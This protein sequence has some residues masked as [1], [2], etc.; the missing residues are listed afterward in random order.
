L[1]LSVEHFE[2]GLTLLLCPTRLAPVVEV[3][4]WANVGSADERP[5]EAGLAHF[6]EHML[7]KGTES[8]GVGDIAGAIEGAGGRINAYTS[9][10][11]TCYHATLPAS[12]AALGLEVLADA[13][14]RSIF[15]PEEISREI[16]VVLEEIRRG[17][18]SPQSVLGDAL[19]A[20]TYR[21]H[22]YGAPILGPAE[23]VASFDR[24]KVRAFFE[25]WYTPEH[26]SVVAVGDFDPDALREQARRCFGALPRG[27]ARRTRPTEP[28]PDGLRAKLLKRPFERVNIELAHPS[29]ALGHP[30]APLLDLL[31]YVLGSGDSCRLVQRVREQH[32]LADRIDASCYTPR[33]PGVFS[34]N[35]E[36]DAERAEEA[37]VASIVELEQLR[38]EPVADEELE[39]A[40]VNF[41]ASEDFERESVSGLAQKFGSFYHLAGSTQAETRYLAAVHSASA[42]DLLRVAREYLL[43][44]RLT[45]AA[46][47]PNEAGDFDE[48]RLRAAVAAGSDR[49]GKVQP[50]PAI[51]HNTPELHSYELASGAQLHVVPRPEVPVVAVRAA[52]RGGLLAENRATAGLSAFLSAMW[53]RGTALHSS[54]DYARATEALP[55]EI[56]GFSGRSSTGFTLET[57]AAKLPAALDLFCEAMLEPAF[58]PEEIERER[59]ETLAAIERREDRLGQRALLL[60]AEKLFGSHPYS[61]PMLGF[62]ESVTGFDRDALIAHHEKLIRGPNLSLAV[63]GSVDPDDVAR[64]VAARLADLE[65]TAASLTAAQPAPRLEGIVENELRKDRA[66]AHLVIGFLGVSVDDSD[67]FTLDVLAQLLAGQGGRLFLELRDRQSLAYSVGSHNMEGLDPG[68]FAVTIA[69]APDKLERARNGLLD[70]LRRLLDDPPD[71]AELARARRHLTGNFLIDRQRN[72]VHA[73]QVSLDA[74]YGLGAD[75]STRYPD[76]I[77]S[78]TREDLQRVTQRIVTL[79]RYVEARVIKRARAL[80]RGLMSDVAE[81]GL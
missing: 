1:N 46:V 28:L 33:D 29:V 40:R 57:T 35:L 25:R 78:I 16:E 38:A 41:L 67:R 14:T 73:A 2:N 54:A 71:E 17:E 5:G 15:D 58:D 77:A 51:T 60:F 47:V 65:S 6:H 31:A 27:T 72:A 13:T 3:Q 74:L 8:R 18:D 55:A 53:M 37:L 48:A 42:D 79:D 61:Q 20:E 36:T 59:R 30:D 80:E 63:A 32:G 24:D 34:V 76:Q 21:A 64:R 56:D 50:T 49:A 66:Q 39:R 75:A 22:P 52:F 44:E 45:V 9:F 43:P 23:S 26:L 4:V 62:S 19:F 11:V 70:E 68:W 7:F 81:G 12:E 69:T 10:D